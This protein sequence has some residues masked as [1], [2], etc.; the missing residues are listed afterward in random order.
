MQVNSEKPILVIGGGIAGMTAALEAAEIGCAVILVEKEATLGGRVLRTH[1]YFPKMCPPACGFE[2]NVQR[3]KKNPRIVVYTRA[4]VTA[5]MG[6]AGAF[7]ACIRIEPR[8]ETEKGSLNCSISEGLCDFS[9]ADLNRGTS[10]EERYVEAAAII[11]ATGWQP[12]EAERLER[13]GFNRCE[14]VITNAMMERLAAKDGPTGG[15]IRR[16]SDDT[17]PSSVAFVQCAGS[18]DD[19]HLPYCSAVCCMAAL[20]QAR[21]LLEQND[22]TK[23]TIFYIDI[24][25]IGRH[26]RFY[27]DLLETNKVTFIKGKVAEIT[28]N[29]DGRGLT[30]SVEDTLS[31]QKHQ[32]LFDMVVLSTG[33]VP[34]GTAFENTFPLQR[35]RYGFIDGASQTEGVF[36][37]GCA[38]HP[39][40]VSRTVKDAAGAALKAVQCLK[41]RG[42]I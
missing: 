29:R 31:G 36:A 25:T 41:K 16:P 24:R 14:N 12:Y 33:I 7:R 27:Y 19:D 28:E 20:K 37:A 32:P 42:S 26:E 22:E 10:I 30:L 9:S 3:M 11:V 5:V 23:I 4:E 15:V 38:K 13:L 17:A 34:N 18:R 8:P 21:Y 40:D 39:C 2:I 6:E 35:D 1:R